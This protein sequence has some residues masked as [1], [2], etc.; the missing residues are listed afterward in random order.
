MILFLLTAAFLALAVWWTHLL[1]AG[2]IGEDQHGVFAPYL[3]AWVTFVG[4]LVTFAP[5][6]RPNRRQ[7]ILIRARELHR[8]RNPDSMR[9][10]PRATLVGI[11]I[12][13]TVALLW[14]AFSR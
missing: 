2:R 1:L 7:L 5:S 6:T 9:M 8:L 14:L 4:A 11:A 10:P 3:F 12:L 13:G